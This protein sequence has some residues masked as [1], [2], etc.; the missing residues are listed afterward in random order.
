M[1]DQPTLRNANN[2]FLFITN[3]LNKNFNFLAKK[4]KLEYI[5]NG[6]DDIL[7]NQYENINLYFNN[8]YSN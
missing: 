5:F 7:I 3:I 1:N 6:K 8:F 4:M 2:I